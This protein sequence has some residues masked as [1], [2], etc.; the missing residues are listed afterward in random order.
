M[1]PVTLSAIIGGGAALGS[2]ALSLFGGERTNRRSAAL[3]RE[4]MA[5][6]ERMSNTAYQ[7]S[8]ADMRK[9]GIN[10]MLAYQ[11][12]GASSPAGSMAPVKDSVSEAVSS[13]LE[14]RRMIAE[15]DNL[16]A[17]NSKIKSETDL[18]RAVM[19]EA[20]VRTTINE[21]NL[22]YAEVW[23]DAFS[24]LRDVYSFADRYSS[25]RSQASKVRPKGLKPK[26]DYHGRDF[27][28]SFKRA[29]NRK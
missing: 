22:P 8:V 1:D 28:S 4:Q 12:G 25:A 29:F 20:N 15:L 2:S 5:F 16:K 18:N 3:S 19:R 10:P 11:Q 9:A 14:A 26:S 6:Q 24:K 27:I 23:K 7:R 17:Q 13:A 21:K